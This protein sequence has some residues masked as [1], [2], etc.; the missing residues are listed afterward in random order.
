[1]LSILNLLQ[2]ASV[3]QIL[4][5]YR[6]F[7]DQICYRIMFV[8]GIADVVLLSFDIIDIV[9][10]VFWLQSLL[11][12]K[13]PFISFSVFNK[14]TLIKNKFDRS[15]Q[16]SMIHHFE[17]SVYLN[18]CWQSTDLFSF[19]KQSSHR[20]VRT[21]NQNGRNTSSMFA[22]SIVFSAFYCYCSKNLNVHCR[23][24]CLLFRLIFCARQ[25]F[26]QQHTAVTI[27]I[28]EIS[29]G[30][31]IHQCRWPQICPLLNQVFRFMC[32]S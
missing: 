15:S 31:I 25:L 20:Q 12:E 26:I 14:I 10:G 13:V 2:N 7:R 5:R 21:Y 16:Q 9:I 8:I 30:S 32:R 24:Y 3:S 17:F 23:F 29:S 28:N 4:V 18:L 27:M 19:S 22:F 1:M 11:L 6:E